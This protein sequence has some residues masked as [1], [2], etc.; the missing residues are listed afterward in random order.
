[1]YIKWTVFGRGWISADVPTFSINF[2]ALVWFKK[3]DPMKKY[4]NLFFAQQWYTIKKNRAEFI[5]GKV[6]IQQHLYFSNFL[7][8]M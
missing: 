8:D 4:T 7:A 5:S 3:N 6:E 1:M 2:F